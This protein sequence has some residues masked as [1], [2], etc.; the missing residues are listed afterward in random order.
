MF[1]GTNR[2]ADSPFVDRAVTL[3]NVRAPNTHDRQWRHDRPHHVA[4]PA[5]LPPAKIRMVVKGVVD[6]LVALVLLVPVAPVLLIC[7]LLVKMTSRG[8]A[9][10][11]QVRLGKGGRP[12]WI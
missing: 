5:V 6:F 4:E 3:S 7:T 12:F 11:S 9:F 8:P 10:Y 1:A 2:H